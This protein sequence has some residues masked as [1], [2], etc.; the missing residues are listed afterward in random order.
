MNLQMKNSVFSLVL[1]AVLAVGADGASCDECWATYDAATKT[2]PVAYAF[3]TCMEDAVN[4]GCPTT[5]LNMASFIGQIGGCAQTALCTCQKDHL[6]RWSQG[7]PSLCESEKQ[8]L[9]CIGG[10]TDAA[11]DTT[12]KGHTI[13]TST[14]T[15]INAIGGCAAGFTDTCQCEK[16]YALADI[17]VTTTRCTVKKTFVDCLKDKT[18]ATCKA[19]ETVISLATTVGSTIGT[20]CTGFT[21]SAC[22]CELEYAKADISSDANI[23]T[24]QLNL[25]SCLKGKTGA[26]CIGGTTHS[27]ATTAFDTT[28]PAIA[29]CAKTDTCTCEA[30]YAKTDISSDHCSAMKTF[31]NCLKDK[32]EATCKSGDTVISLATAIET[33]IGTGCT[34]FATS[35][36]SCELGYAKADVS[37]PAAR[38]TAQLNLVSCLKGKT[39]AGCTAGTASTLATT[40]VDTTIPAIV[41]SGTAC[42][43]T[44][45]CTC[46]ANYAKADISSDTNHCTALGT[47]VACLKTKTVTGCMGTSVTALGLS[48]ETAYGTLSSQCAITTKTCGCEVAYVKMPYSS[49][50]EKC[51]AEMTLV[52]CLKGKEPADMSC[53]G[54]STSIALATTAGGQFG[55]ITSCSPTDTCTACE[56]GYAKAT[57]NDPTNK[58]SALAAYIGCL[59]TKTAAGCVSTDTVSTLAA[60]AETD[61]KATS[62]TV[63]PTCQCE[64]DY[65]KAT[66][67]SDADKCTA[68]KTL[69]KCLEGKTDVSCD[70][71]TKPSDLAEMAETTMTG[72]A[73]CLSDT[74]QCEVDY[75]KADHT[76]S[77]NI[78]GAKTDFVDCMSQSFAVGCDGSKRH[79]IAQALDLAA[80][81]ARSGVCACQE[82]YAKVD[83]TD[84]TAHCTA[85]KAHLDCLNTEVA[86]AACKAATTVQTLAALMETQRGTTSGCATLTSTCQCQVNYLKHTRSNDPETC[87]ASK[88][89]LDCLM[90]AKD[91]A[92]D[93]TTPR[94][95]LVTAVK[96]P[97][98]SCTFMATC[99]GCMIPYGE[100]AYTDA[101]AHCGS[102]KTLMQCLDDKTI[103]T[104]TGCDDTKTISVLVNSFS[105]DVAACTLSATCTCQ[106]NY[107]KS[108]GATAA[109]KCTALTTKM[110]CLDKTAETSCDGTKRRDEVATAVDTA[111]VDGGTIPLSASCRTDITATCD[112]QTTYAKTNP[113]GDC[114]ALYAKIECIVGGKTS[115]CLTSEK[116]V[117]VATETVSD[118]NTLG[119]SCT[120]TEKDTCT[121]QKTLALVDIL[122]GDTQHCT[123][124]V[125]ALLCLKGK[126]NTGCNVATVDGLDV[127]WKKD[128]DTI[129]TTNCAQS[130]TCVCE[131]AYAKS[132]LSDLQKKCDA[133][134]VELGCLRTTTA[135]GCDGSSTKA[136]IDTAIKTKMNAATS[137]GGA[138]SDKCTTNPVCLCEIAYA[139]A[140]KDTDANKCTALKTY[141][142][143]LAGETVSG[144]DGTTKPW[145]LAAAAKSSL[146]TIGTTNC[147]LTT[148]CLCEI[149]YASTVIDDDT[150]KCSALKTNLDCVIKSST[151]SCDGTARHTYAGSI[152]SAMDGTTGCPAT[153][154]SAGIC[155]DCVIPFAPAATT[156]TTLG[157][158]YQCLYDTTDT[159]GCG[160]SKTIK[161][162]VED[163]ATHETDLPCTLE[164]VCQCQVNFMK[165]SSVL[166]DSLKVVMNCLWACSST[167]CDGTA[168]RNS[169]ATTA[170]AKIDPTCTGSLSEVC[171]CQIAYTI[172]DPTTDHCGELKKQFACLE[173]KTGTGCETSRTLKLVAEG[174]NT[175]FGTDSC[176]AGATA[177]CECQI[178]YL[179]ADVTGANKCTETEK[180]IACL[181]ATTTASCD[182]AVPR[183]T[184]M[185]NTDN[186]C[187][188]TSSCSCQRAYGIDTTSANECTAQKGVVTCLR[189]TTDT[190]CTGETAFTKTRTQLGS[191]LETYLQSGTCSAGLTDTCQCQIDY[192]KAS[193]DPAANKCTALKALIVCLA[194][195]TAAACDGSTLPSALADAAHT[196][197][198]ADTACVVSSTC[199][200]EIAYA[201]TDISSNKCTAQRTKM[202]CL[203]K[204]E[205]LGCDGTTK[206]N[207]LVDGFKA[208]LVS[209]ACAAETSDVCK[210]CMIPYAAVDPAGDKC[211]ALKTFLGCLDTKTASLTSCDVSQT[212]IQLATAANQ[213]VTDTASCTATD[214]CSCTV[215]YLKTA[216]ADDTAEC[217]ALKTKM[218][219][220][221]TTTGIA[222][223]GTARHTYAGTV[224]TAM[225]G[226]T[227]C[228]STYPSGSICK[229]CVIPMATTA[230]TC[231]ALETY[232]H[233]LYTA[234]GT[235]SCD[236]SK[237][238]KTLADDQATQDNSLSC[239]S[240]RRDV[241][242]CQVAFLKSTAALCDS[243]K[244]LMNCLWAGTATG[245][246]NTATR[247]AVATTA[248]GKIDTTCRGTLS[249]VCVCQVAYAK[250]DMTTGHCAALIAQFACLESKTGTGCEASRT[251][252]QVAE[253]GNTKFGSG[254][255]STTDTCVCQKAYL[256][257]DVSGANK[258]TETEKKIAC[259]YATTTASCDSAVPRT[260]IMS[261]TD[262]TCSKTSSCSCQRAYGIDTTSADECAAQK[263]VVTCLRSTTDTG[264]TGETAFTKTRAQLGTDLE[265]YL[266]SGTCSAGLTDTCQCQIDYAKASVDPAANKCTALK[267]LIVCLADKTAAACDGSTLPS[268]LA[269]A[270]HTDIKADT[271]CVVSSTCECEIAYAK[272][273]ISSNK[274]TAQRTKMECLYKSETLGCDGTTKRNA[275]V[276]G[277]KADLVSG[278]CAAE[279][280]DV[281]KL[282]MIPYAAVDPAGDKCGALK[283]FLGCLDTKTASLTSCDGSQTIIQLATAADQAVTDTASCTATDTCSCTV[284]Y[285]KTA[286]ADETAECSALKTKMDCLVTTTGIACD[287][288]ARHTYAGTVSTAMDGVTSC[289]STYP[290]GSI[291]KDCVIPM[292]TTAATCAALETYYHCLY[293]AAGTTSCDGSKNIKTLADDQAT[294]DNSL[295]CISP[296]RDVCTCQVAFLKS[297]AALCDSLKVLMNCLWAGT[298]NGCDNTATRNA[299]ATTADG[300]ID[301]SC[302]GTLSDVCVCQVAYAKADMT[303]DALIAQFACLESKTGTGCEASRT[304]KQVAEEGNTKFGS[305]TCS[306]T[307]TCVCQKAYLI[308][309]VSGA[310]KCTETEKKIA[311][312]YATTSASCDSAVP[313]TTIM[314]NTDNTCS[315]TSSCSCQRAY[316]IDTTSANECTAQKGVVTCLRSTTDTG[317]TGEA[318]FTKT[319]TQLGTDLETYLTSSTCSAGLTDTCQCQIDYAKASVDPAANKCTALGAL[320]LCLAGKTAMACDGTTKP[321]A[322]ATTAHNDMQTG[323][324]PITDTCLCQITYAKVDVSITANKCLGLFDQMECVFKSIA[325][326][327]DGTTKRKAVGEGLVTA[328][329]TCST[330]SDV[331][332]SCIYAYARVDVEVSSDKCSGL[333]AFL[334]CLDGKTAASCK[335]TSPDSIAT[336]ATY[337]KTE[338]T[339]TGSTCA[340]LTDTCECQ[341][342][343]LTTAN[344]ATTCSEHA[345]RMECIVKATG[346]A[347][348]GSSP[349]SVYATNIAEPKLQDVSGCKPSLTDT[350]TACQVVYAKGASDTQANRC[351]ALKLYF[352]C[353]DSK[354]ALSCFGSKSV[355]TLA[356]EANTR[357]TSDTCTLGATCQCQATFLMAD[358]A[359]TAKTCTANKDKLSCLAV[360]FDDA[361]DGT[362]TRDSVAVTTNTALGTC[363]SLNTICTCEKTYAVEAFTDDTVHCTNLKTAAD[364]LEGL[365]G[366]GCGT[367]ATAGTFATSVLAKINAISSCV[368]SDTC[369]CQIGFIASDV[370]TPVLKCTALE[371]EAGCVYEAT[372]ASCVATVPKTTT[373]ASVGSSITTASCTVPST[374]SCQ[375][376]YGSSTD[377]D[378]T[379]KFQLIGCLQTTA[380]DG[381][382]GH[383]TVQTRTLLA[384]SVENAGACVKTAA[385]T[386]QI[387]YAKADVTGANK[388]T[389]QKK[390][391]VCLGATTTDGC[392]GGNTHTLAATAVAVIN[393]IA[394]CA[395]A[396]METCKCELEFAVADR[397]NSAGMCSAAKNLLHCLTFTTD[398]GCTQTRTAV[399]NAAKAA[400]AALESASSGSCPLTSSCTCQQTFVTATPFSSE[401]ERCLEYKTLAVCL[402]NNNDA[403]CD[404]STSK[405]ALV[406]SVEAKAKAISSCSTGLS[407]ST[408]QCEINYAK[409]D[410]SDNPK[411]CSAYNTMLTCM[412]SST[413]ASCIGTAKTTFV[414]T[415]DDAV[416]SG[417]LSCPAQTGECTCTVAYAK[418]D[419]GAASNA[420]KCSAAQDLLGCIIGKTGTGCDGTQAAATILATAENGIAQTVAAG[421]S[422]ALSES[423]KCEVTFGKAD[424][425]NDAAKC[426]A[427]KDKLSCL[428]VS[429]DDAC[430]GT[431][432]R[433]SVAVT[434]NAALG[435][436]G[437]L[438]TIC[439]CEKNYAVEAF[440]DDTVHCNKL[441]TA[442]DCLEGLSGGGC[443]TTATAGTF[444]TSVLAK[445]N[446]ISSCVLSDTCTCQIG[447]IAADV[448]TPALKCTALEKEAGCVY[449]ATGA[450][451]V[452]TVPK[453]TTLASVGSSITTA[454]CTVPSTCT[455]QITYGSSTDP[456]CTKKFQLIGCLQTT[457][458]DGCRGHT[459]VQTRT[460]LAT[461]VENAG[462]CVKTDACTCQINYAKADVTGAN[463][464]TEQKK[465]AV[466]L[467]ATT[468][469]GCNGGNAHTLAATAVAV[470]NGIA[471][472][473]PAAME[474]CKCELEF[475]VA[476]RSNSAGMCSAAKNLLHCLTFTTDAGCTQTRTAVADAAKA[477][478][479]ALESASSGSCPLTSSCTCQQTFVTATPFSIESERCLEYK[480]LAVCLGNNN[481][482]A[483]DGSTSKNA[484]VTSVEAKAKAISSCSTGLSAST[485]QCEINYAKTDTSDNPK[486][487]SAYNTM[488]TCMFSSTGASCI[489]TA[490]TTFVTTTDDAV[491]SGA[492]SCPAQTAEC[493]CTVAYAKIDIGAATNADKCSAAQDLLGCMTGKTGTGCDG[494]QAAATILATAENGIAQTV[495]DG[496]SC[497]L[498]ESCK[499]E[500]TFG[501]ADTTNDAAYCSAG[502]NYFACLSVA[503][504]VGC[505]GTTNAALT[506]ASLA[507]ITTINGCALPDTC[508]CQQTYTTNV[509]ANSTQDCR[510]TMNALSCLSATTSKSCD[511][512]QT[513]SEVANGFQTRLA[514]LTSGSPSCFQT[515][516]CKCQVAYATSDTTSTA[517]KCT[518]G[519]TFSTCLSSIQNDQDVGCDDV[520]QKQYLVQGHVS[521]VLQAC[522]GCCISHPSV[523][524]I[525]ILAIAT[526][527]WKY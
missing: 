357:A 237:N 258:C 437:S 387:N 520:T 109:D 194:D 496:Y 156:C 208:D 458:D 372:G 65:A 46:E 292:A 269:D 363:G 204:S 93:G 229:E 442:A 205:T 88:V 196:D 230:A 393:G 406:T 72:I 180:K 470:I 276:D 497:A 352:H 355:T 409:T 103:F 73:S 233:C 19:S 82:T 112:C 493:I 343:F 474:T 344:S 333:G 253:E 367:T 67:T 181:Y 168:K 220:L 490:K 475:A 435:T 221:V 54:A 322:L 380:D 385:C 118:I 250:A 15:D 478:I 245:C 197:I 316:G 218:D 375:I 211:G 466:C 459:T 396:A 207:A 14:E 35:A 7:T 444:A 304:L 3:I 49:D 488:L 476:D 321:S 81:P 395:P 277:F 440:T 523:A 327:C 257:A 388:C 206:R 133:W 22:S 79:V 446:A 50:G 465:L 184:I 485:C 453:T 158:Y 411:K 305:G 116:P 98:T 401:S 85:I 366:G 134:L 238:I 70:T 469:D 135:V 131:V 369:T 483:C 27:L 30:T 129:G 518:A 75:V 142:S 377:A 153:Y 76:V 105:S 151:A 8:K 219:C 324:C 335:S 124:L 397:S 160:G 186:T 10:V 172:V 383:T 144:C 358:K 248:D 360:S 308:A 504:D 119:A 190:G 429:F 306:T 390:L 403:A 336:L 51:T 521:L 2:C 392:N 58:C 214:T 515:E 170:N 39:G 503:T 275:L 507:K 267:A 364:C 90:T 122:L 484:L 251:L 348:D 261:N 331:C 252:K 282:C 259:L 341:Y 452:A 451:C 422:C 126:T 44:V 345:K 240:P 473:A 182:A 405:N 223:D 171:K 228:P 522:R 310:N 290:S 179:I 5:G 448:S 463:K 201:K 96:T 303:C 480:T 192:A 285:L 174:G 419:I 217:S 38:C 53:D 399:A 362:A 394:S 382:R 115:A 389:E 508:Q 18:A 155:K 281:C 262:D 225:D 215:V 430:D 64:I 138:T 368:L 287:G 342:T 187:S 288:T 169:V 212:I 161:T 468:T 107:M 510:Y 62:C 436:C 404:G 209:G 271:A 111:I 386:C 113:T 318:A 68:S 254:T 384:T 371:K 374:C 94:N 31:V 20:D 159:T 320:I 524:I 69:V 467:G 278:A 247:N 329:G 28:I 213:A 495:A 59:R 349:R 99:T 482:A 165:S 40:A 379:K 340:A 114:A 402:G 16:T 417:A 426:S 432:T 378:C 284:V 376:T 464:C 461:S 255:C 291:C 265:T 359:T 500:V 266:Q 498:T 231:A 97:P 454:S 199:E 472:C 418:I 78:C 289:P 102:L 11:C 191:G 456:D 347:C 32:S 137:V 487:C 12:T 332:S 149:D 413:G 307:D 145:D 222:C 203:Y 167:A 43:L 434:T 314:A 337:A 162:L 398:A 445:I 286:R 84:L 4:P 462:A 66:R 350:C 235:T 330:T 202:E 25:V 319:R 439:T 280:S 354:T 297:T 166:C 438:N 334:H 147:P 283:T 511:N 48:A 154:A 410:T 516:T 302:R 188:K 338:I 501:K 100:A 121:C 517:N 512:T 34:D 263:G 108:P 29:S 127:Q 24:A 494:T 513:Q 56:L 408:C 370:S 143:C 460:L 486:K 447:F 241:C 425:T 407:A 312:L 328:L 264:C 499:C 299:V 309:D 489:G 224:S 26:G 298:A 423:C 140:L 421:H 441:K 479:A 477:A 139:V 92:C 274:C 339:K 294:Q 246:D 317:C 42:A 152:K 272:T 244:V 279:T 381:C 373:L 9:G 198:K 416:K 433:D 47:F 173:G 313:R 36:C 391:A 300:K 502:L 41:S 17:S 6:L 527:L 234:A 227:S 216:R 491:K 55:T 33:P 136:E 457:A 128:I 311:C 130:D 293:T 61:F 21:S 481:D 427:N 150:K 148:T 175:K 505:S 323:S 420:D 449:E 89:R 157:T 514:G 200:C 492:L 86:T 301:T 415:T 193:V 132:D 177:A 273:D 346:M 506:T 412:F 526:L 106:V 443:G 95:T 176:A 226:V 91:N 232:Y 110:H 123:A 189:S 242:T 71:T 315:K 236:G 195:K 361:C 74:C 52:S 125:A 270:A 37:L 353:L 13:A 87:T 351:A 183:T 525:L 23:C 519:R 77:G 60:T 243:L 326:G 268:A 471:S 83:N 1:I 509:A 163:Q 325:V 178:A 431:T 249:D 296:R 63:T 185:S 260:T 424:T 104:D 141:V 120:G 164:D 365:S 101:T 117:A 295:S 57:I 414:T 256:I 356:V 146:D 455:C 428:A 45:T 80:C 239:I 400:I 450:S 210:L